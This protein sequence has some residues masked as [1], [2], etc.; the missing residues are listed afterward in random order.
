MISMI[1]VSLT[2]AAGLAL[3][4]TGCGPFGPGGDFTEERA[5][6]GERVDAVAEIARTQPVAAPLRRSGKPLYGSEDASLKPRTDAHPNGYPLPARL[7]QRD[8]IAVTIAARQP[9]RETANVIAAASGLPVTVIDTLTAPDGETLVVPIKGGRPITHNGALAALLDRVAGEYNL[10]WRFDGRQIVLSSV[11]TRG[12]T[13]PLP[14]GSATLA[15][16]SGGLSGGGQDRSVTMSTTAEQ[17][18]WIGLQA[19]L[20]ASVRPPATVTVIRESGRVLVTGRPSDLESAGRI[21]AAW[22]ELYTQRITMEIGIYEIDASR[23]SEFELGLKM[24]NASVEDMRAE[25]DHVRARAAGARSAKEAEATQT[26]LAGRA[27]RTTKEDD[28]RLVA[29]KGEAEAAQIRAESVAASNKARDDTRK[30]VTDAEIKVRE[31]AAKLAGA[32]TEQRAQALADKVRADAELVA[33]RQED[34][35]A[36]A[37]AGTVSDVAEQ[38]AE[39][40]INEGSLEAA[41]LRN[42][43]RAALAEATRAAAVLRDDG[44]SAEAEILRNELAPAVAVNLPGAGE[45][46]IIDVISGRRLQLDLKALA[47]N[48]SV[49][50]YRTARTAVQS[51]VPAPIILTRQHD[52]L[53]GRETTEEGGVSESRESVDSGLSLHLLP[54]L[55]P[56]GSSH[57]VQLSLNLMQNNLIAINACGTIECPQTESRMISSQLLLKPGETLVLSGYEQDRVQTGGGSG[58]L[59]TGRKG[60]SNRTALVV[61]VRVGL[62]AA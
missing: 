54:R 57:D 20:E 48:S 55:V 23:S 2:T 22:T 47:D 46:S 53:A 1:R 61:I 16:S 36:Q 14:A 12:W 59:Y 7:Q 11:R 58:L 62:T 37:A 17:D 42:E 19:E 25:R 50:A 28:A 29:A 43:G 18:P 3:L 45:A 6:T 10:F 13:I 44:A 30:A 21:A 27:A 51:G 32:T 34:V 31:A 26:E 56:T 60:E 9:I 41:K 35:R 39:A 24:R 15:A 38:R 33:A 52:F 8:A 40:A 5:R 4:L 49:L